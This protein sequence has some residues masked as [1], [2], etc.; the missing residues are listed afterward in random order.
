MDGESSM[1]KKALV[2]TLCSWSSHQDH[3]RKAGMNGFVRKPYSKEELDT[4]LK[5]WRPTIAISNT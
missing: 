4:L 5:Q 3:A 1:R 2:T